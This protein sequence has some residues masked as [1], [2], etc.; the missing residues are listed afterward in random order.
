[1]DTHPSTPAKARTAGKARRYLVGAVMLT[2]AATAGALLSPIGLAGADDDGTAPATSDATASDDGSPDRGRHGPRGHRSSDRGER[3]EA[4]AEI[5]GISTD[6]LR[7]ALSEGQTLAEVA[8][9]NGISAEE[10]TTGMLAAFEAHQDE[11]RAQAEANI[12][13]LINRDL[14]ERPGPRQPFRQAYR[15]DLEEVAESLGLDVDELRDHIGEGHSLAEAAEA[16]GVSAD[17]LIAAM[18]AEFE[19]RI[20]E[21]VHTVPGEG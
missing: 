17:D 4:V 6:D 1:M 15:A 18:V 7:T 14:S 5:I 3:L 19:A 20:T 21:R 8:E 13:D 9:A 10:L 16:Q 12:D 11:H 2:G